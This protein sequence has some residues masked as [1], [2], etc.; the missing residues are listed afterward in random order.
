[1]KQINSLIENLLLQE[2]SLTLDFKSEQY[3]FFSKND[4]LKS[5]LLKDVLAFA[6][7]SRG[8]NQAYIL[9]G[10]SEVR[11][12]RSKPVGISQHIDDASLQQFIHGKI[13]RP[14]ELSYTAISHDGCN[15]GLISISKCE[16]P[17]YALKDYG[18][19]KAR[20]VWIKRGSSSEI[21]TPDEI[22]KMG[23][24]SISSSVEQPILELLL[25]GNYCSKGLEALVEIIDFPNS[26]NIPDYPYQQSTLLR[27]LASLSRSPLDNKNYYRDYKKYQ[28]FESRKLRVS[29]GIENLGHT[30]AKSVRIFIHFR[31]LP[32]HA[33]VLV[34]GCAE[35]Y[36]SKQNFF[37]PSL[38]H[39]PLTTPRYKVTEFGQGTFQVEMTVEMVFAQRA[40]T[41]LHELL[42]HINRDLNTEVE[43]QIYCDGLNHPIEGKFEINIATERT[44]IS[45]EEMLRVADYNP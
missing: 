32:R 34:E 30:T 39:I 29:I 40:E 14:I 8:T 22:Y 12:G 45:L 5:E 43:Y 23:V 33:K 31:N 41:R 38:D 44:E 2:E 17:I 37:S 10:V 28:E 20:D 26:V 18:K 4:Y 35:K 3:N 1:M 21:A 7:A 19:V 42:I 16:R 36:P 13:N 9:I 6:N 11:G 27:E 24:E 25:N 15:L